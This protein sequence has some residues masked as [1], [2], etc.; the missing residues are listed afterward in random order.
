MLLFPRHFL[1]VFACA[2][3]ITYALVHG[4]TLVEGGSGNLMLL[5]VYTLRPESFAADLVFRES[6]PVRE[7]KHPQTFVLS[8]S[9]N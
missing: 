6:F 9:R 8:Q 2:L 4:F 3:R 5:T 1:Y 7:I